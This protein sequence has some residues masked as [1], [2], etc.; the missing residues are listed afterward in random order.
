[1]HHEGA[2]VCAMRG[3]LHVLCGHGRVR[4][5]GCVHH[6]GVVTCLTSCS[7]SNG[8]DVVGDDKGF[9]LVGLGL[10]QAL[11]GALVC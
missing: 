10:M 4:G 7:C 9:V 11:V 1:M 5:C 3:W 8:G 2:V 6:V